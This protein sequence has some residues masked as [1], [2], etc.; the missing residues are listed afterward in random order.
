MKNY[1]IRRND[2]RFIIVS[3]SST[4]EAI[5]KAKIRFGKLPGEINSGLAK[6]AINRLQNLK[7]SNQVDLINSLRSQYNWDELH[8]QLANIANNLRDAA[9]DLEKCT[10]NLVSRKIQKDSSFSERAELQ[11]II[12]S[13]QQIVGYSEEKDNISREIAVNTVNSAIDRLKK[14]KANII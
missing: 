9:S 7:I 11:S 4:E 6:E 2:G 3:A 5:T 13:L 1:R 8:C 12:T 14:Y 10:G